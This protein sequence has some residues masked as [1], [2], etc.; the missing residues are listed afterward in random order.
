MNFHARH[1]LVGIP[2]YA[3]GALAGQMLYGLTIYNQTI[4][5]VATLLVLF[6]FAVLFGRD[7]AEKSALGI[8]R[9]SLVWACIAVAFDSVIV[10]P[11]LGWEYLFAIDVLASYGIIAFAPLFALYGNWKAASSAST[12]VLQ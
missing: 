5:A 12:P 11:A 8:L 4:I 3:T 9:Y 1:L 2:L 7:L 6:S 10:V